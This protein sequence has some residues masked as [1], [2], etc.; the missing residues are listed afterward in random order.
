M[1]I[2][3]RLSLVVAAAVTVLITAGGLLFIHQ[4]RSSL[5]G[6]LDTALRAR[7]DALVQRIGPD[8]GNDFQD[9]GAGALLPPRQALAQVVNERGAVV[10]S[11]EGTAGRPLLTPQQLS[12]ARDGPLSLSVSNATGGVR[13]LAVPV[14]ATGTP[15][16]VI[17]VGTSRDVP[18]EAVDQVQTWLLVGGPVVIALSAV[19]T[20][21]LAGAALRPVERMRSQAERITAGD[22]KA[23]LDVLET[24]DEVARLGHTLNALLDRL[25]RALIQQQEFVADAGH[26]LRTPLTVLR[27]ELELAS[28]PGRTGTELRAAVRR[29]AQDTDRLS[30]LAEDLRLLARADGD[31][32]LLQLMPVRLDILAVEAAA[33]AE[34]RAT[35]AGVRL[36][37]APSSPVTVRADRDRLRQVV[38]NLLDNAL[39]FAPSDS[40]ITLG[41]ATC[42]TSPPCGVLEVCDEGPGF[43]SDFLPQAFE[44][45]RRADGAR[46]GQGGGAG[47]GLSIV[48]SLVR[49]HGGTVSAHNQP[50]GGARL[51]VELPTN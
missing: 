41:V 40:T 23:R 27:T 5:D 10:D 9:A 28:R 7:A 44:R 16:T 51:R 17:I 21:L 25:N 46:N 37:L 35:T 18:A 50:G 33:S 42:A 31:Q 2:R 24:R 22:P 38:D 3:A 34:V 14:P 4:L 32:P 47:L 36:H 1:P 12:V 13:L 29:A 20:W 26:E 11:S 43:P 30:R 6:A 19:G 48:A 49:A 8:G 45:F 39:R 15:P